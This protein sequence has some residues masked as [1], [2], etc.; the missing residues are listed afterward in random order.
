M[1]HRSLP[2]ASASRSTFI[3]DPRRAGNGYDATSSGGSNYGPTNQKLIDRV[4]ADIA[5]FRQEN[6][7]FEGPIPA[8]LLTT[9]ASGLDP[10]ISPAAALAQA[11]RVA[12]VRGATVDQ[13]NQLIAA[14]TEGRQWG[15]LG[16]PRIN[17]LLLN[18]DLIQKFPVKK[19]Y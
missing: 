12:Q 9:S 10:D 3:L 1:V 16:E 11:P 18:L 13:I 6:P 8:D 4:T 19:P 7:G 5:K 2:K 17:V 15:F 14:H